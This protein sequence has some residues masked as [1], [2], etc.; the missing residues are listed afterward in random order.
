MKH[1]MYTDQT[2]QFPVV[3][4]QGNKYI[5]VLCKTDGNLILVKPMKN[6]TSGKIC[7]AY[8]KLMQQLN[9]CGIKINKY[10]LDN[11]A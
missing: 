4:S 8:E 5:M 3:S 6:R 2:R 10:I 7:K 11:K 9:Q 1:V